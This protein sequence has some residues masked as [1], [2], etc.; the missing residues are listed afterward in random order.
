MIWSWYI[1]QILGFFYL[2]QN[3]FF[4]FILVQVLNYWASFS[5]FWVD[6]SSQHL[7]GLLNFSFFGKLGLLNY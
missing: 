2:A 1:F 5:L 6:F 3:Y 4:P 7:L